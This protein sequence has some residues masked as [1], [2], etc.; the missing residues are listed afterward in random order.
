[1]IWLRPSNVDPFRTNSPVRIEWL[2]DPPHFGFWTTGEKIAWTVTV[3]E[4]GTYQAS[5]SFATPTKG[6]HLTLAIDGQPVSDKDLTETGD[7]GVF[8][9]AEL[10]RI[11]VK[12]GTHLVEAAWTTP[13]AFGAGNLRE[14]RMQRLAGP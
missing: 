10:G 8:A 12:A 6:T 3:S 7:W 1:M 4:D 14:L 5:V 9:T 13:E 11:D 2:A